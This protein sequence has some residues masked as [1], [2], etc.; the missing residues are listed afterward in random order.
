[1][2]QLDRIESI[3]TNGFK[4]IID[5]WKLHDATKTLERWQK[6]K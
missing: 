3:L 6:R 4:A 5:G 1:M 2:T